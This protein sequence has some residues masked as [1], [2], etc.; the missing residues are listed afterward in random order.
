MERRPVIEEEMSVTRLRF[1]VLRST[2]YFNGK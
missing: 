2:K 1:R